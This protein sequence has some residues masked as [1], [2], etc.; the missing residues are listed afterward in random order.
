MSRDEHSPSQPE[1]A[2][3]YL[4]GFI[5]LAVVAVMVIHGCG[6]SVAGPVPYTVRQTVELATCEAASATARAQGLPEN[7]VAAAEQLCKAAAAIYGRAPA[8]DAGGDE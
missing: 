3:V 5:V 7:A 1:A 2:V 8:R 4:A 6:P